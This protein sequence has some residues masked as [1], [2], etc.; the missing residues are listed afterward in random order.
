[1]KKVHWELLALNFWLPFDFVNHL[2]NFSLEEGS[3]SKTFDV[4]L[5]FM[6]FAKSILTLKQFAQN[7]E[8]FL[9]LSTIF[10]NLGVLCLKYL[11]LP[12]IST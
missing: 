5:D 8:I 1:M 2:T 7:P 10:N 11:F 6:E 12:P 3:F 4:A 9:L